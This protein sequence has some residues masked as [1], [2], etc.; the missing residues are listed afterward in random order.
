MRSIVILF[1]VITVSVSTAFAQPIR[2]STPDA[3]IKEGE[4]R[5]AAFDYYSALASFEKAYKDKDSRDNELAYKIATLH[6]Q[7]R[8]YAKAEK[9]FKRVVNKKYR[10]STNPFLPE[11]RL[12]YG[13]ILKQNGLYMEAIE[14]LRLYISEAEDVNKIEMAKVDLAGAQMARDMVDITGMSVDNAGKKVNSKYPEYSPVQFGNQ[15]FFTAMRA[16]DVIVLDGK[17]KDYYS[18]VFTSSRSGDEWAEPVALENTNIHREGYHIGNIALDKSGQTMYFTRAAL[19]GNNLGESNIFVSMMGDDGWG[20]ANSLSINSDEYIMKQP[21]IGELFGEAALFFIS[22]MPG[23]YGGYDV[24][25]SAIRGDT[26]GPPVNL[27]PTINTSADEETPF[28]KDG[29]IYFSSNGHPS[30][31]GFDVFTS[32]WDGSNWSA[33]TNMGKPYNSPADDLYYSIDEEGYKGFVVSN[34]IG[35]RSVKSKTCCDDIWLVNIDKLVLDLL[36]TTFSDGSPLAGTTVDLISMSEST[37]GE[38]DQ[39]NNAAANNFDFPLREERAYRLIAKKD[40]FFPDTVDFNTVG[41]VTS[42]TIEKKLNLKPVPPPPPPPPVD[43]WEVY[44]TNT[45]IELGNIY[46]DYDKANILLEAEEDLTVLLELMNKYSDMVIELSSHTDARGK[47]PYNQQLSQ[48]R[49]QSATDW[50]VERGVAIERIKPVGYGEEQ[51]RNE[52]TEGVKCDDDTHR[53]NRRTEFKIL[54][55][56]T[57]IKIEKKR[58]KKKG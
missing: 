37:M 30:I 14:E 26:Y 13:R 31:G 38:T 5:L 29:A 28:Y 19:D 1:L 32:T 46:Y 20:A 27:G 52:C 49:A 39:K 40:G 57:S 16:D 34:R 51:I 3:L 50:L 7:L 11:A 44:E 56:P 55:G 9:W 4:E 47:A 15:L 2:T 25:Y 53:Y 24:Y 6:L 54:S 48:R 33:P 17:T 45:P 58:L 8:D 35:G 23:G 43:E 42:T 21:A 22:D 41:L 18:K 10:K 36:A 12:T